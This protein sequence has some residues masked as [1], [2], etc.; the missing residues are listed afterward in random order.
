M[1]SVWFAGHLQIKATNVDLE[2]VRKKASVI[3]IRAVSGI[4]I[5]PW[6]HMD[7]DAL[8]VFS[9]KAIENLVIQVDEASQQST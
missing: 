5:R 8:T 1:F 2:Q 4:M 3:D 6:T 7:T 9:G